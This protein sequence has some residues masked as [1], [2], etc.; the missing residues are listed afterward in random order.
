MERVKLSAKNYDCRPA[1]RGGSLKESGLVL[2][3]LGTQGSQQLA[4]AG[5]P[6]QEEPPRGPAEGTVWSVTVATARELW[7]LDRTGSR[8]ESTRRRQ[9]WAPQ[10]WGQ[11]WAEHSTVGRAVGAGP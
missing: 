9:P 3:S 6:T 11:F 2:G 7:R 1:P 4:G 5:R 8:A 10:L